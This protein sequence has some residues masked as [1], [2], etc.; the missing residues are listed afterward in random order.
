M[1]ETVIDRCV[2]SSKATSL[3]RHRLF[4]TPPLS[5]VPTFTPHIDGLGAQ[6]NRLT[7]LKPLA[8][9]IRSMLDTLTK[10]KAE[11]VGGI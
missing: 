2:I 7:D 5:S 4:S 6:S 3:H 8:P 10:G 1:G 11:A 9:K